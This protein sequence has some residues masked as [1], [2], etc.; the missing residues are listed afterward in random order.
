MLLREILR[1][2][3]IK[4]PLEADEK[5]EAIEEL[6]DVLVESHEIPLSLR[7]HIVEV[8]TERERSIST[9]MEHGVALPHGS[10]AQI[11]DIVGVLGLAPNGIPFDSIDG[12]PARI[13]ILLVVPKEKFQAHVRT[14]AGIAHLLSNASLREAL[15]T[16][17][18]EEAIL[19][20][21]MTEEDGDS[22]YDVRS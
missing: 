11:D 6:V 5:F 17:G 12:S 19:D 13:V 3:L 8:V 14:L 20:L 15:F 4:K 22:F 7:D 9:G 10:T 16:V 1:P 18:G 21:I 2:G